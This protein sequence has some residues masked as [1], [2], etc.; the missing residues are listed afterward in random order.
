VETPPRLPPLLRNACRVSRFPAPN[1]LVAFPPSLQN[2]ANQNQL[3]IPGEEMACSTLP[4]CIADAVT[5]NKRPLDVLLTR[6]R[7]GASTTPR[8]VIFPVLVIMLVLSGAG[9]RNGHPPNAKPSEPTKQQYTDDLGRRVS[10][11]AAPQRIIS[12]APSVTE[13]LFALQLEA[14]V[15]GVTSYC[16]YPEGA[17]TK[18]RIGDTL[19]PNLERIIALKPDL[20][21][22]TTAS[23]LEA[24]TRQMESLSIPVYVTNPRT[25]R[26]IVEMIRRLGEV[27]GRVA[28]ASELATEMEERIERIES[29]VGRLPRVSVLYL[30]QLDPLITA[31][32][33]TFLNDLINLAGG[34]SISGVEKLDYP[35]FSRETVLARRPEVMLLS[36][37][38]GAAPDG[39]MVDERRLRQLFAA[40]P[41]VRSNRLV[42]INSDWIDRPGPRIIDGLEQ[43][44]QALHPE[45][46]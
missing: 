35:Q 16:D 41:A 9:C 38:H 1:A 26:G 6:R 43:I 4:T 44:A 5:G 21:I 34:Q 19:T 36:S 8:G 33:E 37:R 29:R 11:V 14:E 32:K 13:T 31:G 3:L 24:L 15:I 20:V 40:T 10:V 28:R 39:A 23:Q 42:T 2:I 7:V 27:T 46:P 17:L 30:L 45:S 25:V 12:L 22:V 18:E